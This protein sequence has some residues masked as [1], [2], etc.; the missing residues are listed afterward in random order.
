MKKIEIG[1]VFSIVT[2]KGLAFFQHVHYMPKI[3]ELIRI[4]PGLHIEMPDIADLCQREE[5]FCIFF[6]LKYALNKK[7]VNKVGKYDI[8]KGFRVPTHMRS[9]NIIKGEFI[10]WHIVNIETMH[11]EPFKVLNNE[12]IKLSPW[13]IWN[14]TLLVERLEEGWTLQSW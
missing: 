7:I 10:E 1:D 5:Q 13:G 4:L 14:D 6:P 9:K 2:A 8:P 12:Q 3:G 11:R